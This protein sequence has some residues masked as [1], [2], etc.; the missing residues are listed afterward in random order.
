MRRFV[1]LMRD[2]VAKAIDLEPLLRALGA[3]SAG[4]VALG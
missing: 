3:S 1:A 4:L 2:L